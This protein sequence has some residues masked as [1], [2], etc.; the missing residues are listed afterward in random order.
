MNES[1]TEEVLMLRYQEGDR[2]AFDALFAR[3]A[4]LVH[5]FFLRTF[6]EASVADDLLQTTFLNLHR[7]RQRY[8]PDQKL[9]PW[10]FAIAANVRM[11]E[12]R[13]RHRIPSTATSEEIDRALERESLERP[14]PEPG[15]LL[16][17]AERSARV[18]AALV[19][20]PDSQ[21]QVIEMNRFDGLSFGEI[22]RALDISEGACKLRAFRGYEALR[23]KLAVLASELSPSP[24][25][26]A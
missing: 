10:L 20:L 19:D 7:A 13:R 5:G 16:D 12:L 1:A 4:P 17:E 22:A 18:R 6:R 2:R 3:L 24:G 26:A 23:S 8:R 15:E 9:R 14:P 21:R 25:G 11:D